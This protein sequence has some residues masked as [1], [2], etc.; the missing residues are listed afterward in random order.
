MLSKLKVFYFSAIRVSYKNLNL[1]II[2]GINMQFSIAFVLFFGSQAPKDNDRHF[3][4]SIYA[5]SKKPMVKKNL[6]F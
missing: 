1:P 6:V 4:H 2:N 5:E 3:L